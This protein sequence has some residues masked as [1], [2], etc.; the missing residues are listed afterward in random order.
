M[1]SFFSLFSLPPSVVKY[2]WGYDHNG[3]LQIEL[4]DSQD[5][6]M[7]W[8]IHLSGDKF[9]YQREVIKVGWEMENDPH[10]WESSEFLTPSGEGVIE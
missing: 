2:H 7:G 8:I 4:L 1:S 6:H 9:I 10:P 3:H 5:V